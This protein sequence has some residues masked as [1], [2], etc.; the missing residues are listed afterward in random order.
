[1][2][3]LDSNAVSPIGQVTEA[4]GHSIIIRIDGVTDDVEVGTVVYQGDIVETFEEGAVNIVFEDESSFAVSEDARLTVDEFVY[5]GSGGGEGQST[6][7]VMKGVFAYTS[8]LVG[9]DDPDDVTID[10]PVGSI[11]IRGTIIGGKIVPQSSGEESQITVIEGAIVVSNGSGSTTLSSQFESLKLDSYD[12]RPEMLGVLEAKAVAGTYKAVRGV[13]SNL[14]T[15]LDDAVKE[16]SKEQKQSEDKGEEKSAA[17]KANTEE[18]KEEKADEKKSSGEEK[19]DQQGEASKKD[20]KEAKEEKAEEKKEAQE[21]EQKEQQDEKKEAAKEQDQ[22][23]VEAKE[24]DAGE[25]PSLQNEVENSLDRATSQIEAKDSGSSDAGTSDRSATK[26]ITRVQEGRVDAVDSGSDAGGTDT[27]DTPPPVQISRLDIKFINGGAA[28]EDASS[29]QVVG[30]VRVGNVTKGVTYSL[31]DDADGRFIINKD[32]GVVR[33]KSSSTLDYETASA[34]DLV[35][36]AEKNGQSLTKTVKVG[37]TDAND[38]PYLH[39]LSSFDIPGLN[40]GVLLGKVFVGDEDDAATENGTYT[41]TSLNADFKVIAVNG[42]HYLK[43][44]NGVSFDGSST[45]NVD[46]KIK[47][48]DGSGLSVD[49][50]Y[51]LDVVNNQMTLLQ[52]NGKNGFKLVDSGEGAARLGSVVRFAEDVNGDGIEDMLLTS[53]EAGSDVQ[54]KVTV[55]YGSKDGLGSLT[56][57][58]D[59]ATLSSH[60][61][62]TYH[63][64][65]ENGLLGSFADRIEDFNN[66]GLDDVIVATPYSDQNGISSGLATILLGGGGSI[67]IEDFEEGSFGGWSVTAVQDFNGDGYD[68]FAVG[69]PLDSVGG[70]AFIVFGDPTYSAGDHISIDTL[71]TDGKGLMLHRD[72]DGISFGS[73]V[74][75][76]GDINGDK[77]GD[78]L[79]MDPDE[80]DSGAAYIYSQNAAGYVVST[81]FVSSETDFFEDAQADLLGDVNNDGYNDFAFS[82][83]GGNQA[84]IMFGGTQDAGSSGRVADI[85]SISPSD[86]IKIIAAGEMGGVVAPVGDF[87]GDGLFDVAVGYEAENALYILY[88]RTAAEWTASG[89]QVDLDSLEADAYYKISFDGLKTPEGANTM[90]GL[91]VSYGSDVNQDGFDDVLI[92]LPSVDAYKGEAY[93]VYGN[94]FTGDVVNGTEGNDILT[95]VSDKK[96]VYGG[97]GNDTIGDEGLAHKIFK[98][99]AGHDIF[100]LSNRNF[101]EIDGGGDFDILR[102]S[103]LADFSFSSGKVDGIEKIILDSEVKLTLSVNDIFNLSEENGKLKIYEG[104]AGGAELN[105]DFAYKGFFGETGGGHTA[106]SAA[107]S[108]DADGDGYISFSNGDGVALLVGTDI[109]LGAITG[110]GV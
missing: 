19:T 71:E 46:V 107:E 39:G 84:F 62:W 26:P 4:S 99:G 55:I 31:L 57:A 50:T 24:A 42:Q 32:T 76:L 25:K 9:R 81:K 110:L 56:G 11:G 86:G 12:S 27:V 68:D 108:Y 52:L 18:V 44:K 95:A 90:D 23:D 7:S 1:M 82:A 103:G 60:D 48:T 38:A 100:E 85:G 53:R 13:A 87:N 67:Q 15:S 101:D 66:D 97:H 98:G 69:A 51:S 105:A 14:F 75:G 72:T 104:T 6:F 92:G 35:I 8:G 102:Y 29:G 3:S 94:N 30:Q 61:R 43:L 83:P 109:Q 47:V 5:D 91:S 93:V 70:A 106:T 73:V 88:G 16:E 80:G 63:G 58:V 40:E 77:R 22:K 10:T 20:A 64:Q 89:G 79:V 41:V 34:H 45:D 17:E 28:A 65:E 36:K 2:A 21:E 78:L 59:I 96:S 49:H 33:V 74:K 54:G 37:V